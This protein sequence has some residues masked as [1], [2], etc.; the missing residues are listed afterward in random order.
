MFNT[1]DISPRD[2]AFELLRARMDRGGL[3]VPAALE[4]TWRITMIAAAQRLERAGI[5]LTDSISDAL[6]VSDYT[7]YL[8]T[9]RDSAGGEPEWLRSAIRNRWIQQRR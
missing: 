9:N 3:P 6:L 5:I 4:T 1:R 8:L 2:V 7:A